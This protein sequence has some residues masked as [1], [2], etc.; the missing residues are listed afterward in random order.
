MT[1]KSCFIVFFD[2]LVFFIYLESA[3]LKFFFFTATCLLLTADFKFEDGFSNSNSIMQLNLGILKFKIWHDVKH[4]AVSP[5]L[6]PSMSTITDI[7]I[8]NYLNWSIFELGTEFIFFILCCWYIVA[9]YEYKNILMLAIYSSYLKDSFFCSLEKLPWYVPAKYSEI[10]NIEQCSRRNENCISYIHFSI[11]FCIPTK[12]L[13]SHYFHN[14][15]FS[16][17]SK[18]NLLG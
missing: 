7:K 14:F 4:I 6:N 9:Q 16:A 12:C 13:F 5:N 15:S 18:N 2:L 10:N 11:N 17:D 8:K 1:C 3:S